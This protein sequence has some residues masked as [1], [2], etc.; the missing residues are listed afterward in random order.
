[1]STSNLEKISLITDEEKCIDNKSGR[2][3]Y[4]QFS[5]SKNQEELNKKIPKN[6]RISSGRGLDV[7]EMRTKAAGNNIKIEIFA[8][9][10]QYVSF[11][12]PLE[13][14]FIYKK[15]GRNFDMTIYEL[16]TAAKKDKWM[17]QC[18]EF[19]LSF[20]V[21]NK[22]F[23]W[24]DRGGDDKLIF[25]RRNSQF[26]FDSFGFYTQNYKDLIDWEFIELK[27]QFYYRCNNYLNSK[28]C[29]KYILIDFFC[30]DFD[31]EN[32]GSDL[33][34]IVCP[35]CNNFNKNFNN[36]DEIED[37]YYRNFIN[38]E[39]ILEFEMSKE[40]IKRDLQEEEKIIDAIDSSIKKSM[41]CYN[42]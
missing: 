15:D 39:E 37:D 24:M 16:V 27:L 1:M 21:D 6:F 9:C 17:N 11:I 33:F 10:G 5:N 8:M 31:F 28:K 40:K 2:L 26:L 42:K 18:G 30:T 7:L 36:K 14:K 12:A 25:P 20:L 32:F 34:R 22:F 41:K 23:E 38:E 35:R 13:T 29:S 4:H 19:I 3:K